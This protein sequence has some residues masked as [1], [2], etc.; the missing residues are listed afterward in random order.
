MRSLLLSGVA[1]SLVAC[2]KP[3]AAPAELDELCAYIYSHM[4]DEEDDYLSAGVANL[5][6]WLGGRMEETS[7]GYLVNNLDQET[8][9]ALDDQERD[10]TGLVGAAV[11]ND[12]AY[13]TEEMAATVVLTDQAVVFPETYSLYERSWR[14][15]E[16]GQ[17]PTCF[18]DASCTYAEADNHSIANYALG[19]EAESWVRA[20][21]RWVEYEEGMA[22]ITRTWMT[23]PAELS[24]DWINLDHQFYM[25]VTLPRGDSGQKSRRLQATWMV[26]SLGSSSVPEATA[27]N[28]VISSMQDTSEAIELYLDG[29]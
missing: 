18:D 26:A 10:L 5:D 1:L 11:G 15:P 24:I 17:K 12:S 3:P 13:S 14:L 8:V 9:N 16:E 7:E 20:Q 25:T 23:A 6:A 19:L 28:M 2:K 4:S 22:L 29:Q 21:Y 27:L